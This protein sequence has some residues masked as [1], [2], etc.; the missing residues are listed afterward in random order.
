[1]DRPTKEDWIETAKA[2]AACLGVMAGFI[3]ACTW[4]AAHQEL[5]QMAAQQ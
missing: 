3:A 5:V 4:M 2:T 1:M